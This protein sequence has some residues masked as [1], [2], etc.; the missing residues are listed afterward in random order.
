MLYPEKQQDEDSEE[1]DEDEDEESEEEEE[2]SEEEESDEEEPPP[3]KRYGS[4]TDKGMK[5]KCLCRLLSTQVCLLGWSFAQEA[6]AQRCW[7]EESLI[8]PH[9]SNADL[10]PSSILSLASA[11][12]A[13]R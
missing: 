7:K 5:Q 8:L 13:S 1:S 6:V 12:F 2:E 10:F 4:V 3:K 11:F 9:S